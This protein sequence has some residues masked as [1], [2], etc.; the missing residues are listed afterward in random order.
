VAILHAGAVSVSPAIVQPN[1]VRVFQG[2]FIADPE[3]Q[4]GCALQ[5]LDGFIRV[6]VT[7]GAGG[8]K[9]SKTLF[10]SFAK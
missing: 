3:A 8:T 7:N 10:Y 9:T 2:D 1:S 6:T 4:A 5:S